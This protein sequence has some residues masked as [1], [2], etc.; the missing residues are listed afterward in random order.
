MKIL[1]TGVRGQLGYDVVKELTARGI[2]CRGVDID[3]FD[4]TDE[5]AVMA[6]V[7]A[8]A[9]TAIIHC[10]AYT[11][12]DKAEE[13]RDICYN[14]NVLG[15]RYI[16]RAAKAVDA[17][18][19]QVST[20]YVYAGDGDA[21]HLVTDKKA[22][23][24][25]YGETKAMGEDEAAAVTDKLFIVRTAW[26]FGLNGNNFVKTMLRL[27]AERPEINVVC[28]QIGSPT[29]TRD[30]AVL[31]SDMIATEKY[32]IYHGCN[33]GL[34]SWYGF[35][36]EIMKQAGLPAKINP[37][38]TSEYKTAAV[39]PLNSRLDKTCLDENGFNRLPAWQDALKRYLRELNEQK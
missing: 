32:G 7:A 28:D 26:A 3:D 17:K 13:M 19:L 39:R 6:Y 37:I 16:A 14:V 8:Y 33:E 35:T 34:C 9:P 5:S 12:V 20:D 22:P 25:W 31:L 29:Y 10:A 30:L 15:S 2:E 18:L 11:A 36:E 1:V 24:S 23:K 21:P 4:L 38:P 27:G